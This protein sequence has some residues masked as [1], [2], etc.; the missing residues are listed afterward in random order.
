MTCLKDLCKDS[1]FGCLISGRQDHLKVVAFIFL[2]GVGMKLK[3]CKEGLH[4]APP[5]G[6]IQ[7]LGLTALQPTRLPVQVRN[8][9]SIPQSANASMS[10]LEIVRGFIT[11]Q[12]DIW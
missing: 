11:V 12:C 3:H 1:S 5:F 9:C 4:R 2:H 10:N 8:C 6:F 7:Q